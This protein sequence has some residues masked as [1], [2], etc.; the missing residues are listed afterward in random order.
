[1]Q[2]STKP[3]NAGKLWSCGSEAWPGNARREQYGGQSCSAGCRAVL[4][5]VK[6]WCRTVRSYWCGVQDDLPLCEIVPTW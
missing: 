5:A 1:M 4:L 2:R 3:K 6:L